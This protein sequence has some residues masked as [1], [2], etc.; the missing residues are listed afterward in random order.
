MRCSDMK[1][2]M[3]LLIDFNKGKISKKKYLKHFHVVN[4]FV[5]VYALLANSYLMYQRQHF[6]HTFL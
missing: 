4:V 6:M 3:I 1:E 2:C 5:C